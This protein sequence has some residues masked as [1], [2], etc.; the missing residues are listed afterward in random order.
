M[1]ATSVMACP[2]R[3]ALYVI[4][5][6]DMRIAIPA[7]TPRAARVAYSSRPSRAAHRSARIHREGLRGHFRR[8]PIDCVAPSRRRLDT[9]AM[10]QVQARKS[11]PSTARNAGA[12]GL[13]TGGPDIILARHISPERLQECRAGTP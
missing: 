8:S 9:G 4:D 13:V 6:P 2:D 11:Q 3:F 1:T 5:N 7:A 10:T 12:I